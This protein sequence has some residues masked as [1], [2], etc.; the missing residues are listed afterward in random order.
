[1][2]RQRKTLKLSKN[3]SIMGLKQEFG[4]WKLKK[5]V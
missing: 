2:I 1:M 5:K 3:F 4:T